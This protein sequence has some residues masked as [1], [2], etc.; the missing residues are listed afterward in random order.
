MTETTMQRAADLPMTERR[1][2]MSLLSVETDAWV[3][4]LASLDDDDWNATTV[5]DRWTVQDV[6]GH[7]CGHAEEV[8]RPWMFP[9]RTYRGKKAHPELAE[10]D[11]HMEAQVDAHRGLTPSEVAALY[12]KVWPKAVRMLGRIPTVVRKQGIKTEIPEM[13]RIGFDYL[14][15]VVFTRDNWMHRD[16]VCRAID[17]EFDA[18]PHDDEVVAQVMR[19]LDRDFWGGPAVVVELTGIAPG[20]WQI[21]SGTPETTIRADAL[22]F[23]RLL[24]GRDRSDS[25]VVTLVAGDQS[26]CDRVAETRVPF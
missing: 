1:Y 21:G 25:P 11:A 6:V 7:L 20:V 3:A 15:D 23:M 4:L 17:R 24:A 13:P 10:L 19:D 14:H 26:I 16:D 22:E 9:V 12:A 5:C 18:H 8:N 2:A